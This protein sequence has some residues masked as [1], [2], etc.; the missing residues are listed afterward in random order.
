M[1]KIKVSNKIFKRKLN[2]NLKINHIFNYYGLIEQ[3]GSI[4]LNV[5]NAVVL[6]QVNIPK[7]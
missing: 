2:K 6:H 3:T 1:E 4:F 7:Y 5:L